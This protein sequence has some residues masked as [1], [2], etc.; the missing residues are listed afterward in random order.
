M[1]TFQNYVRAQSLDE[2]WQLN[3]KRTNRVIGGMLWARL[4]RGQANTV[5]DLS[6]LGLDK[7]EEDE[8]GF[9]IGAM[10][11]LRQLELDESLNAYSCGAVREAVR[12]IVGVQFRN[13]ATVGGS[14][15]GRF[16]FSD[17]LTVLL[18]MEATV[19]LYKAG[20]VLLEEFVNMKRDND[21]LVAIKL[22]K[23]PCIYYYQSVRNTTTD[24]P[25]LTCCAAMGAECFSL[26][27]GARPGKALLVR[28]ERHI[29][30]T[31]A[32]P[33]AK[34]NEE[35]FGRKH[36]IADEQ[37]KG[38]CAYVQDAVPT[39][40]NMR[41]SAEYRTHLIGVLAERAIERLFRDAGECNSIGGKADRQVKTGSSTKDGE[42]GGGVCFR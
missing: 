17:V 38:F 14:I 24:F 26:S 4:S 6:G 31:R 25:V 39:G 2:A 10:V 40:S 3:Q 32:L 7:I 42:D 37:I 18:A 41:A 36:P 30:K 5:I 9:T 27:I 1:L 29:L 33:D 15:F 23:R 13:L 19:C 34:E 12:S 8:E 16:G 22:K 20:E 35:E 21:I 28:D 11:T